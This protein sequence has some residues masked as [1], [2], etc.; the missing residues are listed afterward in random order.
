MISSK[1]SRGTLA[2]LALG[3]FSLAACSDSAAPFAPE[4]GAP[5]LAKVKAA[6]VTSTR[7]GDTTI[8]KIVIQPNSDPKDIDLGNGNKINFP[9]G[10]SSVCDIATSTYGL[11]TWNTP[12]TRSTVPVTIYAITWTD[13]TGLSHADFQPAMRFVP[14]DVVLLEMK[15][16]NGQIRAGMRI[17]FCTTFGCVDEAI[18]DPSVA[19]YLDRRGGTAF[20]RIKHFSGYMVTVGLT[21][22]GSDPT[23]TGEIY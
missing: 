6:T 23:E 22:D 8:S 5:N 1:L 21:D 18:A 4:A 2:L 20:R 10:A 14:T 9:N 16:K 7:I 3:A 12:C 13:E 15:N 19:T 11:G 17:D